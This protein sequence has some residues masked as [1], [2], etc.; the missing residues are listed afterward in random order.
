MLLGNLIEKRSQGS[1]SP[2][3]RQADSIKLLL[4]LFA[5]PALTVFAGLSDPFFYHDSTMP[6]IPVV[7]ITWIIAKSPDSN[8]PNLYQSGWP[9]KVIGFPF[10]FLM[11]HVKIIVVDQKARGS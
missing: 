1:S 6:Q 2:P 5:T 11:I 9:A 10:A 4:V 8:R 3:L 7:C